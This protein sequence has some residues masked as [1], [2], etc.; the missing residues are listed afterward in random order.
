MSAGDGRTLAAGHV[1]EENLHKFRRDEAPAVD[2]VAQQAPVAPQV[3][4][5]DVAAL[6]EVFK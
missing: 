1:P 3:I 4:D 2:T 5:E 6:E